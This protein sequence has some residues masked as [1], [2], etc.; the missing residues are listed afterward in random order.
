MKFLLGKKIGMSQLFDDK[1][2]VVPVTLV[3]AGPVVVT[4]IISSDRCGYD[5]IQVGYDDSRKHI[6]KPLAGHLKELG[7]FRYLKEFRIP[8]ISAQ[9]ADMELGRKIDVSVFKEGDK[10]NVSGLSKGRG[11]QG[12]V[13]R[14]GFRGA[15]ASH[16]TKHALRSPGSIGSGFPQ[17]VLKGLRMAGHMGHARVTQEGL[18]V[19][20][21]DAEKNILAIKGAVPG[22]RGTL[23][24]I[25]GEA[26]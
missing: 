15:P 4:K 16:G 21:I 1:G 13:K 18:K 20:K 5:A 7:K 26:E 23:L 12:V 8:S 2:N 9:K 22:A 14:H 19:I 3:Q 6:S 24:E 17:H 10:V 25:R 11:F